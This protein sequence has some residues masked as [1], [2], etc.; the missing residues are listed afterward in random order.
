MPHTSIVYIMKS[1]FVLVAIL[2]LA[3]F[4]RLVYLGSL[5]LGFHEDEVLVGYVGRFILEHGFDLYRN[6]WPMWYFDKFG[7]F[8]IIGPFYLSGLSTYIFGITEFAVRFPAAI[9]GGLSVL[10]LY[11][12][13]QQLF[14]N[15]KMALLS[16]LFLA[17]SPWHIVFSRSSSEGILG[18]AICLCAIYFMIRS[19]RHHS[20]IS[21]GVGLSCFLLTYW[22]YHPFRVYTPAFLLFTLYFFFRSIQTYRFRVMM[23][24]S[25]VLFALM[26]LWIMST[27]W[28]KGRLQQ[29]SIFGDGSGVSIRI[30]ELI[31]DA[32][33]N[34][35]MTARVLHNKVVGYGREFVRQYTRYISPT[36][37]FVDGWGEKF[38]M[39]EQ[40]MFY[41]THLLYLIG[42]VWYLSSAI[43]SASQRDAHIYFLCLLIFSLIPPSMTFIN[44]P[45]MNR[46]A[47]FGVLM[48]PIFAQGAVMLLD[49]H[50][51]I[52]ILLFVFLAFEFVY[53]CFSY[54]LHF[55]SANATYRSDAMKPLIQNIER[56]SDRRVFLPDDTTRAIYYLFYTK[57]FDAELAGKFKFEAKI[58]QINNLYFVPESNCMDEPDKI[59]EA[60]TKIGDIVV[61][62]YT[63]P[64]SKVEKTGLRHIDLIKQ[65]SPIMGYNV[66]E[67]VGLPARATR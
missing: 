40:G 42:F 37:L 17:I 50:R 25:I 46:A 44:S 24:I 45:N 27:P 51:R 36:Y 23:I 53:F 15:K 33:N 13:V 31:Y 57:N 2:L 34:N 60:G 32:G 3:V 21:L 9:L 66:Y 12:F 19:I 18:S 11:G 56:Y 64:M 22:V 55:D 38:Y 20:Y 43:R 8:Y 47:M 28:G 30:Q 49:H 7:D 10:P 65:V 14:R 48:I 4:I 5:P 59:S 67:Y 1:Y 61:L 63:C 29:T 62:K 52:S 35:I 26:T 39:R 54:R 6:P 41:F 16:A 58:P